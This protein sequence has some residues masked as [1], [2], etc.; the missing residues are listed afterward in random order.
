MISFFL[1]VVWLASLIMMFVNFHWLWLVIFIILTI[2]FLIKIGGGGGFAD[3][4]GD[5]IDSFFD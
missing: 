3:G 4:I 5:G 2:Y 1:F